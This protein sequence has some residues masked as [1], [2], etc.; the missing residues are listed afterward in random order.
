MAQNMSNFLPAQLADFQRGLEF[1]SV[2]PLNW[3]LYVQGFSWGV[4]LFES[5]LLFV[6]FFS[7]KEMP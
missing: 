4:T 2:Y 1:I 3:K 7:L 5:Y 6:R